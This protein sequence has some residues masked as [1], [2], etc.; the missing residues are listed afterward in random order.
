[1]KIQKAV[2]FL[3]ALSMAAAGFCSHVTEN[4]F[5]TEIA[6]AAV[7]AESDFTFD[8][9]SGTITK[10]IGDGGD[11]II[12]S[13]I[14]GVTVK[15]IGSRAF[16]ASTFG[17]TVTSVTIP[18]SV[19]SIGD[20]AF[21]GCNELTSLVV[22]ESVTSIGN[23]A[24]SWNHKLTSVTIPENITD[25][26]D[27][28]F[29][30]CTALESVTLPENTVIIGKS[31]FHGCLNLKSFTI[32]ESVK[33]IGDNAFWACQELE[34]VTIPD[35]VE[36]IGKYAFSSCAY[37]KSINV[38]ESNKNY[39]DID[40]V[41]FSKDKKELITYPAGKEGNEYIVPDCTRIIAD[42]SFGGNKKLKSV[43][44]QEGVTAIGDSAFA[45]L[46]IRSAVLPQSLTSIG[47]MAFSYCPDLNSV[48]MQE[49]IKNI[50]ILAFHMCPSL[51][52]VII[53]KSV[54][55][56][57]EEA[58]GYR[59][60]EGEFFKYDISIRGYKNSEAE[61]YADKNGFRF[62]SASAGNASDLY[63]RNVLKAFQGTDTELIPDINGDESRNIA[64]LILAKEYALNDID[65]NLNTAAE[66]IQETAAELLK[67]Y[68]L[69]ETETIRIITEDSEEKFAKELNYIIFD[70][71][72][73]TDMRWTLLLFGKAQTN[74]SVVCT[75]SGT[76]TGAYPT[77]VPVDSDIQYASELVFL[78]HSY[79]DIKWDYAVTNT[80]NLNEAAKSIYR[81][82]TLGEKSFKLKPDEGSNCS[83]PNSLYS[84]FVN[85][86]V[87]SN[88]GI[89]NWAFDVKDGCV[90]GVICTD[91]TGLRTGAYPNT[92]PLNLDIP[93]SNNNLEHASDMDYDWKSEYA[94]CISADPERAVLSDYHEFSPDEAKV[95]CAWQI[96]CLN[97]ALEAD[98]LDIHFDDGE[99]DSLNDVTVEEL[100]HLYTY[101]FNMFFYMDKGEH[102]KFTTKDNKVVYT[103][104][105]NDNNGLNVSLNAD[106]AEP[107]VN[108]T[109]FKMEGT[110][111]GAGTE[112]VW[113]ENKEVNMYTDSDINANNKVIGV[114]T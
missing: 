34:S 15:S 75:L 81:S 52:S 60:E 35:N 91:S 86:I 82:L 43:T 114:M 101:D 14:D 67:K 108:A 16:Y 11:V 7:A 19:T 6:E 28:L 89:V 110:N 112:I 62:I 51:R 63:F 94:D 65:Q 85:Y 93:F 106:E 8:M 64:D 97:S 44:V 29:T 74:V 21:S 25:I 59:S 27:E 31:A 73:C 70:R 80:T 87:T 102:F 37:M 17:D 79:G 9:E 56:I 22:P 100:K 58:F 20:L 71:Y 72:G 39:C 4:I 99:H 36:S 49:G 18:D 69:T 50:G 13:E 66:K 47:V 32:P 41:L 5:R 68:N 61:K 109:F 1:M 46:M 111:L 84:N 54:E 98:S 96:Y 57:G 113:E 90:R 45:G 103:E 104:Y 10:Y 24:F 23:S 2:S 26:S 30:Y 55:T 76:R 78:A 83:D 107:I 42:N 3:T 33:K 12:P 53:P 95:L 105:I 40:G 92:V 38:S 88:V 77:P 48:M